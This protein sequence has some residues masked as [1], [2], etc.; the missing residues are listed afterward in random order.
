MS[1]FFPLNQG[2]ENKLI[3]SKKFLTSTFSLK[4]IVLW[5]NSETNFMNFKPKITLSVSSN[6]RMYFFQ[7][8][9]LD[10]IKGSVQNSLKVTG[11]NKRCQKKA[12][13]FIGKNIGNVTSKKRT[14]IQDKYIL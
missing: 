9:I 14:I 3:T 11:Y 8:T 4:A 6:E 7:S 12:E 13:G 10:W 5:E 1:L 2:A